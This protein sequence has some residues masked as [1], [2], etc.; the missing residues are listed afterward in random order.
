M[1]VV[2]P[3]SPEREGRGWHQRERERERERE[4]CEGEGGVGWEI[5]GGG[6]HGEVE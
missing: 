6:R 3:C 4:D 1:R 2:G 5:E